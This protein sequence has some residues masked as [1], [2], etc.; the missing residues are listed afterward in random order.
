MLGFRGC[1]LGIGYPE[2]SAMQ[3]RAVFEAA[4]IVQKEGIKVRPEIMI[5][6]VGFKKELDL[7]IEVVH[8]AAREVQSEQKV[9]LNYMVGTMIEIPRGALTA[10]EIAQ[11]AE[12]FSF[13]T[14]DLT[15]TG[16]GMSR[17]DSGS[18]LPQ[19]QELEIVKK[20][21]FAT[22]D[23]TGVGQLVAIAVTKGRA[24][25]PNLKLGICG[26][27]GGDPASIHFFE[28]VGLD[29]VSCS[30]YRVPVARLAAAQAALAGQGRGLI[31]FYK[32]EG[33]STQL[34]RPGGPRLAQARQRRR[35][36]GSIS[37]APTPEEA[38][39]LSDVFHFHELA[40]EDA[41]SEIHHPKI[42]SYGDYLY[43]ILHGIDFKRREHRFTTKDIDFFLGA[44]LSGDGPPGRVALDRESR[45]HLRPR[46]QRARRRARRRCCTASSTR[47]S[48]TTGRK[49]TSFS[50][51]LDKLENEVFEKPEPELARRILN[52]KQD[53]ASL[54]Q[55]VLPQRDAVGRLAR[56]E[57]PLISEQLAYRFRDVHDH[58]VRLSDE[59]MFFQDRITSILDAHL[60]AVS[61]QLNSV[62]K[63]LTIIATLFMP[64]TVFTGMYGMNVTLPHLPGGERA[65]FWW[66]L[67]IMLACLRGMLGFFRARSWI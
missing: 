60:S 63:V 49:S 31:T 44:Q 39:I 62:M 34:R 27:H 40:I 54:R 11:S 8:Q 66:I 7:Q 12:F 57:F 36:S 16:L 32:H 53:V 26:E 29:Y 10:D 25:R 43:L 2:I 59:A 37:T 9:K 20:N 47:W 50:E 48:T 45:R 15:Q 46:R 67:G 19:Y 23:A 4:A 51:R 61:N 38:R 52:F 5:P 65:Q 42:E 33:G 1:R 30:P 35:A 64:L 17:D 28:K 21:P 14:N 56:R 13:G 24:T 22:I 41:L 6:L 58:L 55:V 18:F 3:A